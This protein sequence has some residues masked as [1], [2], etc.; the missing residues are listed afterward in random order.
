MPKS[1][2]LGLSLSCFPLVTEFLNFLALIFFRMC[3]KKSLLIDDLEKF[4][5]WFIPLV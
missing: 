4:G 1:A 5:V 2:D 3:T